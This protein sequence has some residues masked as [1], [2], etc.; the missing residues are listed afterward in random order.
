M[1]TRRGITQL[2]EVIEG[3]IFDTSDPIPRGSG[4]DR[5]SK[6]TLLPPLDDELVLR[7]IW[8]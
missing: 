2:I 6:G 7:R 5:E 4:Q 1:M 3:R 8:P